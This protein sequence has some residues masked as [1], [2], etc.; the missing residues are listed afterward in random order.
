MNEP[1][2]AK[3]L[4][5]DSEKSYAVHL[6]E[7]LYDCRVPYEIDIYSSPQKMLARADPHSA[8]VL[9]A[10]ESSYTEQVHD[11]GFP[12]VLILN[13]TDRYLGE[14]PPNISKYQSMEAVSRMILELCSKEFEKSGIPQPA[15]VRNGPPMRIIGVYTPI[16]RCLQTTVSLTIG[17][18]LAKEQHK[19]LYMNFEPFSGLTAMLGR[20]FSG[21]MADLVYYND[22]AREKIA[23]QLERMEECINGLFY[24][25]PIAFFKD[26][27]AIRKEQ[28]T[29]LFRTIDR[30]T[31]FEYLVLDLTESTDGLLD[32]LRICDEVITLTRPGCI[33]SE[34][35]MQQ[36]R[37]ILRTRGY[38]DVYAKSRRWQIPLIRELPLDPAMLTHGELAQRVHRMM[39]GI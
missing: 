38:E 6:T 12:Q 27:Q 25:P 10:A 32:I 2:R 5:C 18:I 37:E 17:E 33:T 28:W 31:D 26:L 13:E 11:A 7:Y 15:V 19:T 24:L 29:D 34:A 30:I 3:I 35:K 14:N 20:E 16:S 21:S 39:A 36:Y 23:G 22:C 1:S 9:V 8:A 4:I